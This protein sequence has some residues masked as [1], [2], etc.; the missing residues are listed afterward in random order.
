M[1]RFLCILILLAAAATVFAIDYV[2][3]VPITSNVQ[4]AIEWLGEP[5][6]NHY[7]PDDDRTILCYTIDGALVFLS[8]TGQKLKLVSMWFPASSYQRIR[9][10]LVDMYGVYTR[11]AQY[12]IWELNGYCI[13]FGI[14]GQNVQVN[15]MMD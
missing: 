2:L 8:F 14:E 3:P 13:I 6:E 4:E 9:L 7:L 12:Y 10:D 5:G 1:N 15:F 11:E